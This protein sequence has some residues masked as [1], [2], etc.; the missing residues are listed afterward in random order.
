MLVGF[1]KTP[2]F[3]VLLSKGFDHAYAG[4][5]V[6]QH[7]GQLGPDPVDFFKAGAQAVAHDM[8]QPGNERQ[9]QQRGASQP[10]IDGEQNDGGHQ[11]HQHVSG[12]VEQV[13]G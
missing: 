4:N 10:R 13:Q 6:G 11:N 8:N 3:A 12:K 5:G 9:W 2:C 1:L 7:I